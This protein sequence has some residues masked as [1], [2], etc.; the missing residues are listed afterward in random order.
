L[1]GR[2][3][4]VSDGWRYLLGSVA[5]L[6]AATGVWQPVRLPPLKATEDVVRLGWQAKAL[7]ERR[8]EYRPTI[9]PVWGLAS[10]GYER[11]KT[12]P[13]KTNSFPTRRWTGHMVKCCRC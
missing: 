12:V 2:G 11:L 10:E 5:M 6:V 8:P 3:W 9:N 4:A 1:L 7:I 13:P